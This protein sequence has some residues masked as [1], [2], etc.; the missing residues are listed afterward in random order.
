MIWILFGFLLLLA[1]VATVLFTPL[2]ITID[3]FQDEI[4][5]RWGPMTASV[6][7]ASGEFRYRFKVPFYRREGTLEDLL[8]RRSH[9]QRE[10]RPRRSVKRRGSG[11]VLQF[12]PVLRSFHA[13]RFRWYLDT[14]DPIWNAWLFPLFHLWH[15][16]GHDVRIAVVGR[17]GLLL[18]IE[19]NGYRLMKAVVFNQNPNTNNNEQGRE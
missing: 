11:H 15:L 19:N 4:S 18:D 2:R 8:E 6:T 1:L 14:G 3:T 5:A 7:T 16:R 10:S 17:S 12:M 13:K 9:A